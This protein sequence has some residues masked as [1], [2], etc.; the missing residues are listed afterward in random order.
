MPG[1]TGINVG[2]NHVSTYKL[3]YQF[4]LISEFD[5]KNIIMSDNNII[6]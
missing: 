1:K 4:S 5:E 6:V 2:K 3:S